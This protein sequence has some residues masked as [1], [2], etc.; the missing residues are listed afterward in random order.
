[1]H[2]WDVESGRKLNAFG[3]NHYAA[4]LGM[5]PDG[6]TVATTESRDST[7]H[8]WEA[9][10]GQE[11]GQIVGH[12]DMV[13]ASAF[14][15]DGRLLA[16]GGMDGA[17]RLWDPITQQELRRF[18]GHRGWVLSAAW[19][20]D[21]KK[22]VTTS[23]D[24]SALVW[25]VSAVRGPD[26]KPLTRA[27]LDAAWMALQGEARLAYAAVGKLAGA[28]EQAV[29]HLAE[30]LRPVPALA[31]AV[32]ARRIAE[33]KSDK[34]AERDLASKELERTGETSEAALRK[35]LEAVNELE[36]QRR[37]EAVLERVRQRRL[38]QL[39]AL[40][41]LERIGG[42]AAGAVLREVAAGATAAAPEAAASLR[43]LAILP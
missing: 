41:V 36:V 3:G 33:L 7:V 40:E 10:T 38:R 6:R 28:P 39:R 15:P 18:E 42:A 29:P 2:L 34:F 13:F 30:Q 43:R 24:T 22:I 21:G 37:I 5:S 20:P 19:S 26:P 25:D 31:P 16:T 4:R 8:L 12:R 9:L 27:E 14:S 35:A 11:R 17:L 1:V 32:L 23:T